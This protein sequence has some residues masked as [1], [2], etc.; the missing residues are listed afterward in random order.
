MSNHL[1]KQ[2]DVV[3]FSA[4][5]AV[6]GVGVVCGIANEGQAVIGTT[7]ILEI[8]ESNVDKNV[9]PYTHFVIPE[10]LIKPR[11]LNIEQK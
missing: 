8:K 5:K 11:C 1:Y 6:S 9:Y 3:E 10:I 4:S 7:Y 2:G